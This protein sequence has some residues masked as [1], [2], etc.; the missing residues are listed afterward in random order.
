[1]ALMAGYKFHLGKFVRSDR[2][3]DWQYMIVSTR[4]HL[5]ILFVALL[6]SI[7]M[8]W[9]VFSGRYFSVLALLSL[10]TTTLAL[11]SLFEIGSAARSKLWLISA[12]SLALGATAPMVTALAMRTDGSRFSTWWIGLTVV[13]W[14]GVGTTA[15]ARHRELNQA[16]NRPCD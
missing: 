14:L 5:G 16:A 15:H 1:M 8:I 11:M 2:F 4:H 6:I 3:F 13:F 7:S 12:I 10:F 9:P